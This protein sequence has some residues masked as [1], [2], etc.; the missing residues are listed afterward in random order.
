MSR[1]SGRRVARCPSWS[2]Q[3][4]DGPRSRRSDRRRGPRRPD[5]PTGS[6]PLEEAAGDRRARCAGRADRRVAFGDGDLAR[7]SAS[8]RTEPDVPRGAGRR[9]R[10]GAGPGRHRARAARAVP[11]VVD[12]VTATRPTTVVPTTAAVTCGP[13]RW[14]RPRGRG[15]AAGIDRRDDP[16][17]ERRRSQVAAS[18]ASRIVGVGA[19]AGRRS[20]AR[21]A[22]RVGSALERVPPAAVA[23]LADEAGHDEPPDDRHDVRRDA[24]R[25]P[26]GIAVDRLAGVRRVGEGVGQRRLAVARGLVAQ[27][28]RHARGVAVGDLAMRPG[29]PDEAPRPRHDPVR[30]VAAAARRQPAAAGVAVGDARRRAGPP[31]PS[32]SS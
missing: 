11:V 14:P 22:R 4:A 6:R 15:P 23:R 7:R 13:S 9:D 18:T 28:S 12:P 19:S 24:A 21:S 8:P 16:R 29:Q 26:P 30:V 27:R 10:G 20:A 5:C 1:A 25:P 31:R 3:R 17:R 2:G 32:R